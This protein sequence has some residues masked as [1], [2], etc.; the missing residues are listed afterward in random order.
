MEDYFLIEFGNFH[1][2]EFFYHSLKKGKDLALK[3]AMEYVESNLSLT[4]SDA[5]IC[6]H[7]SGEVLARLPWHSVDPDPE[8]VVTKEFINYGYYGEWR[9]YM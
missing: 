4:H 2:E 9:V 5:T 6:D 3:S 8:S 1:Y 7:L